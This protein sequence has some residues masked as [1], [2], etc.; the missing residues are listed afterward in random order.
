MVDHAIRAFKETQHSVESLNAF[1]FP[2]ILE[3]DY[4]ETKRKFVEFPKTYEIEPNLNTY[5]T[6]IEGL[7]ESGASSWLCSVLA[8]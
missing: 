6:A 8:L 5:N 1:L 2:C 4:K 3:K 7:C